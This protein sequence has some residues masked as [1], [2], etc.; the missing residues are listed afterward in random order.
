ISVTQKI[1][2]S[3][4]NVT[5]LEAIFR[6]TFDRGVRHFILQPVRTVGLAPD[7]QSKLAISEEDTLPYL[8]DFLRRTEGL[9]AVI[10][11]YGFSRQH[12]V[13]GEHV[14]SEQNRVKN[15]YGKIR[16]AEEL[17]LPRASEEQRPTDGRR[18][19]EVRAGIDARAGF[20]SD[21]TGP[22]LDDGLQHGLM[23]NF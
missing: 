20:P 21:G 1:V 23:L 10:K 7:L 22:I 14:E 8:N 17:R 6:A 9:G 16:R 18:W 15:I 2:V 19:I 13:A 11:P 3:R 12:L 4:L 5:Q